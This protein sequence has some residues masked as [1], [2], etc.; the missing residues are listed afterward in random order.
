MTATEMDAQVGEQTATV[1]GVPAPPSSAGTP[2]PTP[3][4]AVSMLR[5]GFPVLA[6][7]VLFLGAWYAFSGSM[8]ERRRSVV[9]PYPHDV[10]Q[11]AFANG[12][13]LT[14]L[15]G[16]LWI[17][18]RVAIVGLVVAIILGVAIAVAMSQAKWIER[19]FYPYAVTL[20]AIPILALVPLI[21]QIWGFEFRSRV[22]VCVIIAIFPII[23]N[24][25][26]GLKSAESGLHD[27][28]TLHRASRWTRFRK[29]QLPNA[30]P[31]MF[32]GLRISAGLSVIG[33]I[34]GEFFF[35]RG[36]QGLGIL[37]DV[38]R[39]R[40]LPEMLV[41]AVFWSAVLGIAVFAFFGWLS[42]RAT[43]SWHESA[44]AGPQ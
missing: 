21:G 16:G 25:L 9:L 30:L 34:V 15:L 2:D 31:A 1:T 35:R 42:N 14:E 37:I 22:L 20:Q 17:T 26:F 41:G 27:L 43:R 6:V 23:T 18:T 13:N 28:F 11:E 19:S 24:T 33:A 3:G 39:Q 36:D 32:T 8:T 12:E 38:Y 44:Q 10:W 7:F 5:N 29:L 4:F 40:L